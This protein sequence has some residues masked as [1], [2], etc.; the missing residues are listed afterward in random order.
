MQAIFNHIPL[1][2]LKF[3]YIGILP[4]PLPLLREY[5]L[6]LR[7]IL[8]TQIKNGLSKWNTTRVTPVELQVLEKKWFTKM[9]YH[10]SYTTCASSPRNLLET[11]G[12]PGSCTI[13]IMFAVGEEWRV[14]LS[15]MRS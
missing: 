13:V 11:V 4:E 14:T 7:I 9:E 10:A 15:P 6:Y 3:K 2:M 12:A 5:P 1:P 8:H